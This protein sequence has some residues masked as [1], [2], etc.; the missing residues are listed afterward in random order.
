MPYSGRDTGGGY[1]QDATLEALK[2]QSMF[3][4]KSFYLIEVYEWNVNPVLPHHS[5]RK[6]SQSQ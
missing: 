4:G 2:A 5:D 6:F 1:K 3:A